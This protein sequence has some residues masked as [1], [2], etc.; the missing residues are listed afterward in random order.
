MCVR[1]L[2]LLYRVVCGVCCVCIV[3]LTLRVLICFCLRYRV[4]VLFLYVSCVH[5][6]CYHVGLCIAV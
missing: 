3:V 4:F 1:G 2:R 6:V 5:G